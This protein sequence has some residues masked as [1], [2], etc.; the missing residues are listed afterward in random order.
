M[1][2]AYFSRTVPGAL[3]KMGA[4]LFFPWL[5]RWDFKA[6]QRPNA[7]IAN[8]EFVARRISRI[9]RRTSTVLYPPVDVDRFIPKDKPGGEYFVTLGRLVPYKN[10]GKIAR[11][12]TDLSHRLVIVG[13]GPGRKELESIVQGRRNIEWHRWV[14]DAEWA[15][16]LRKARAFVFMAEEDFGIAPVEAQA[17]GVPVIAWGKGGVLETVKSLEGKEDPLESQGAQN[18]ATGLFYGTP[19]SE[20]LREGVETFVRIEERFDPKAIRKNAER[21]SRETFRIEYE[22]FVRE[23]WSRHEEGE[24]LSGIWESEIRKEE[25]S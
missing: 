19:T 13:D 17:A 1:T 6:G 20:G 4:S 25:P 24:V 7:F 8:S 3:R 12:F 11:A 5:R 14:S 2:E 9:Y 16:I 18:D 10:L 21:F 23:E 15:E 22:K